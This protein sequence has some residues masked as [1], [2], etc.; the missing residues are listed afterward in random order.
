MTVFKSRRS[1]TDLRKRVVLFFRGDHFYFVEL[2]PQCD[3]EEHVRLNPGTT[4]V[5]NAATREVL[6]PKQDTKH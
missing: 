4:R 1:K 6:C 5:E 2:T 3:I